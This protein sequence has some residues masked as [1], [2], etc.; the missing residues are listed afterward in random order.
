M[1]TALHNLASR[2]L[3]TFLRA[4]QMPAKGTRKGR[5]RYVWI[6]PAELLALTDSMKR[7]V[8]FLSDAVKELN[9]NGVSRLLLHA[10]SVMETHVPEIE[11]FSREAY[12]KV[13]PAI[14][15]TKTGRRTKEEEQQLKYQRQ[16]AKR[17]AAAKPKAATR[18]KK[19]RKA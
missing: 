9:D 13:G 12:T 17:K 15:A 4:E 3:V 16:S 7:S 2:Q 10:E 18:A 19:P 5:P 1:V 6:T 14:V 11:E 8:A